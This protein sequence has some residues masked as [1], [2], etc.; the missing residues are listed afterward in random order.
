MRFRFIQSGWRFYYGLHGVIF[1]AGY[2]YEPREKD[3]YYQRIK[4][5]DSLLEDRWRI[6]VDGD[7]AI[8]GQER[9]WDRPAAHTIVLRNVWKGKIGRFLFQGLVV[10]LVLRCRVLYVHSIYQLSPNRWP[11]LLR[12]PF[13]KKVFDVHGVVPEELRYC[14]N[15]SSALK[16]EK[17]E[18]WAVATCD[19]LVVV[20]A[21][22]EE[23]L[24]QK[25]GERIRGTF[26]VL[27]IFP[28]IEPGGPDH[29]C[30]TG[31]PTVV[32]AGGTQKWQRVPRM[33]EI[34]SRTNQR[35]DHR[36]YCPDP[37]AVK[38]LFA[39]SF[40]F[41]GVTIESK[42][43]AEVLASYGSCQYGFLLREDHLINQ[44]ACPT[45]LIEY[46]ASGVI[47]VMD[48]EKVGGLDALSLQY[49]TIAEILTGGVDD[50]KRKAMARKNLELYGRLRAQVDLGIARLRSEITRGGLA[51]GRIRQAP[52]PSPRKVVVSPV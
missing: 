46:L 45:K 18:A 43:H 6:Y 26:I 22:M 30:N 51:A 21:R 35:L 25:Y 3:G 29:R 50:E 37:D 39:P 24:V 33:V 23:H 19:L 27:P 47:P 1:L 34:I 38:I 42:T 28:E 36:F 10:L 31:R 32:Y 44:V 11:G 5:I 7:A 16:F 12:L 48:S 52:D 15:I 20:S 14:G 4:A 49:V 40:D 8:P 2:P 17:Q 9:F 41:R 13:V